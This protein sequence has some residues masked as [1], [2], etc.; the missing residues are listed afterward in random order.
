MYYLLLI[1]WK[2]G[3]RLINHDQVNNREVTRTN[4]KTKQQI[5]KQ[6]HISLYV[7]NFAQRNIQSFT[8]MYAIWK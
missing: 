5:V 6:V 2:L 4:H 8:Y 7:N 3:N 1:H